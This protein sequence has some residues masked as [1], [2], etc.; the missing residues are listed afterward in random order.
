[1]TQ[2]AGKYPSEE[3]WQKEPVYLLELENKWE[4]NQQ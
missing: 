2:Q 3:Q 1:M 4:N